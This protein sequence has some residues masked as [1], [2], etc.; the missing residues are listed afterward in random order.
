ML[1]D[2]VERSTPF[3]AREALADVL[4]RVDVE[5][6]VAIAVERAQPYIAYPLAAQADEVA[7]YI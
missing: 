1:H 4:R 7:D 3:P 2:E 6:G 5:G